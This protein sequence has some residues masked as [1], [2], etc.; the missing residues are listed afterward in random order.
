MECK[1]FYFED[2]AGPII[3]Q[4]VE[5]YENH[6]EE[7]FPLYEYLDMTRDDTYDFS[8]K[9]ANKLKDFVDNRISEDKPVKI[10]EGYH[11]RLY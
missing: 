2:G 1:L 6:F 7:Q 11:E 4:A 8:I 5:K 3:D 9:G 10:P